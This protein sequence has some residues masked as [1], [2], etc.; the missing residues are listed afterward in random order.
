MIQVRVGQIYELFYSVP[1]RHHQRSTVHNT[2]SKT[3]TPDNDAVKQRGKSRQLCYFERFLVLV[4]FGRCGRIGKH[5][6][7]NIYLYR[8][9]QGDSDAI[10]F[11]PR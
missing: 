10:T 3:Q 5:P 9:R 6:D 1:A 2:Q 7:D 4:D 8:S 11:C